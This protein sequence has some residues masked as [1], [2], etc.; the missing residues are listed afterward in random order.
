[1]QLEWGSASTPRSM[2]RVSRDTARHE[3]RLRDCGTNARGRAV[4]ID[5]APAARN[6]ARFGRDARP[7]D[8]PHAPRPHDVPDRAEGVDLARADGGAAKRQRLDR[9]V[10][11]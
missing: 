4:D 9:V 5:L 7:A 2:A 8:A 11:L 3:H 6:V 10:G 1:V